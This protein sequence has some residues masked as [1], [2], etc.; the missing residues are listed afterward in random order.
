[1]AG[2][3]RLR[4]TPMQTGDNEKTL[5]PNLAL[6]VPIVSLDSLKREPALHRRKKKLWDLVSSRGPAMEQLDYDRH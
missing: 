4:S 2:E 3:V 1:M 6:V 5:S